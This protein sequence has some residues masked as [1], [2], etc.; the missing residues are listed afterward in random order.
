MRQTDKSN[1]TAASV[2]KNISYF[3]DHLQSYGNYIQNMDTHKKIRSRINAS[4]NGIDRLCDIG[5]GGVFNYDAG[6]VKKIVALDLFFD[7][8]P[9]SFSYP[10]NVTLERGD[11]LKIP[12]PDKSFDGVLMSMLI[13]HLVGGTVTESLGN[14]RKAIDEAFRVLTFGGKLII[15]ESCIPSWFFFVEKIVFPVASRIINRLLEHPTTLQYPSLLLSQMVKDTFH[16]V[17]VSSIPVG[18]S[19]L[20]LGVKFPSAFTPVTLYIIV[21]KKQKKISMVC[22][23]NDEAP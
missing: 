20:Q 6:R 12:F 14:A 19:V 15:V 1:Q 7:D 22:K 2:A 10:D 13:H 3:R 5:N 21:A 4:L 9:A 8:L 11:V 18:K 17:E 16:N 23:A